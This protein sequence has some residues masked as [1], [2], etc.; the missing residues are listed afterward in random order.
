MLLGIMHAHSQGAQESILRESV[1]F[2][3]LI[4]SGGTLPQSPGICGACAVSGHP[5]I[6]EN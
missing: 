2:L 6:L 5:D 1:C 4:S 3:A